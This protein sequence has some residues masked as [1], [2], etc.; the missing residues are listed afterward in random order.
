MLLSEPIQASWHANLRLGFS[1]VEGRSVLSGKAFDGPLVV[2]KPLY[3]E[4]EG[5]CHA[6]LVHPPGG[7]AGGDELALDVAAGPSAHAL[8]TTP[9]AGKWYRTAGPWARQRLAF[10]VDGTLEWLPRETIVFDGALADFST[11]VEL[12]GDARS[13]GWEVLCL[14][15][16]GS[17][18]AFR[19]GDLRLRTEVLRDGRLLWTERGRIQGGG[20]LLDCPAGLAG[21]TVCGT[22]VAASNAFSKEIV[23]GCKEIAATTVLPGVLLARYLG[24]SSEDAMNAFTALWKLLRPAVAGREASIPRIWST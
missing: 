11:R 20:S 19:R 1:R 23:S 13:L 4:G 12:R 18:E 21:K 7:I 14:G 8:L 24:D 3:P 2:Q 17:G 6:I 15:R 5:V 22:L 10:A 16:T 9:G